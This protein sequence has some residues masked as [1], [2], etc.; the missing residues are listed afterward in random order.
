MPNPLEHELKEVEMPGESARTKLWSLARAISTL[1]T[2]ETSLQ[3]VATATFF[4]M[5]SR[6]FSVENA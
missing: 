1:I 4:T 2:T 3:P 6:K 5:T